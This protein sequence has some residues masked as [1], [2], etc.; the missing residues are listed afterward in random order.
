M[1]CEL[2]PN[3]Q[4]DLVLNFAFLECLDEELA[5]PIKRHNLG[6]SELHTNVFIRLANQ[7]FKTIKRKE[8]NTSVTILKLQFCHLSNQ[9]QLELTNLHLIHD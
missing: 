4:N 2:F 1:T 8:N 5:T 7:L 6:W 9:C 3:H